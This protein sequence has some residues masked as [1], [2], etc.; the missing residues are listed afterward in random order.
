[1]RFSRRLLIGCG[2]V[3]LA[4]W[5]AR[6]GAQPLPDEH[7]GPAGDADKLRYVMVNG[8]KLEYRLEGAGIPV[9]FVHGEG[10]SHEL[11]TEQIRPFAEKYLVV[12]YDCRGHGQSEAPLTG[13]SPIAHAED[14]QRA[15]ELSRRRRGALRRQFT[16]RRGHHAVHPALPAEGQ[17][18]RVRGRRHRPDG[19]E[20]DVQGD[21]LQGGSASRRRRSRPPCSGETRPRS[22]PSPRSRNRGPR[23]APSWTGWSTSTAP[24]SR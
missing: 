13:Y 7:R 14:L 9:I 12:A 22:R 24:A 15:P 17:E 3:L 5:I 10:Y 2:G 6:A 4:G 18:H 8:V 23:R 11:W 21:R 20:P 19:V 16:G 1:M